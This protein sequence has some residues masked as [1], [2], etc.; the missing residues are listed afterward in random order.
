MF[1]ANALAAKVYMWTW[2][3][4]FAAMVATEWI[5]YAKLKAVGLEANPYVNAVSHIVEC[6][7]VVY[8]VKVSAG[9]MYAY[10]YTDRNVVLD[11]GDGVVMVYRIA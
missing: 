7:F 10:L 6:L 2:L 11:F 4:R 9:G 8:F 3:P 5:L 1:N